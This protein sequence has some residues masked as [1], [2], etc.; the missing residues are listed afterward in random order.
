[1]IA[2]LAKI[3]RATQRQT[4]M[5]T[6]WPACREYAE[7]L[8]HARAAFYMHAINDPAWTKDYDE[9]QLIDFVG[10]LQ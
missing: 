8:D 7:D 1:M 2:W 5:S 3:W 4:D 6:L 9:A 10:K